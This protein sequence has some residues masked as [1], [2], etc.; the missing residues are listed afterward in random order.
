[1]ITTLEILE[2]LLLP[3]RCMGHDGVVAH[4][5]LFQTSI[6]FK[7]MTYVLIKGL[8]LEGFQL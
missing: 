3:I 4:T 6:A 8:E 5:I 2:V 1:M 7:L